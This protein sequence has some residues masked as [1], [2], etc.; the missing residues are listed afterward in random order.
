MKDELT[1]YAATIGIELSELQLKQFEL[2][3]NILISWSEKMNLTGITNQHEIIV[4]HFVDSLSVLQAIP[5]NTTTLIDIGTGAGFPGIPIAIMRPHI[6]ITLLDSIA[7]KTEFLT[8][9]LKI[10]EIEKTIVVT[11]RA[12]EAAH[13]ENHRELYDVVTARA[14]AHFPT[15]VEYTL[16]F[17]KIGGILVAQKKIESITLEKPEE[18]LEILG[19]TIIKT[20]PISLPELSPREIIIIQK[21]KNTPA[22]Y[23][24]RIGVPLKKPLI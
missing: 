3:F 8:E 21:T 15:L 7:K 13:D 23:P 12:E 2:F 20:I 9:C 10:L 4:K 24:R 18:A 17:L 6:A 1:R 16:P 22:E 11:A 5:E 14:V 19:G